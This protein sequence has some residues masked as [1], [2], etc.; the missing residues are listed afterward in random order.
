M[1][2]KHVWNKIEGYED[3]KIYPVYQSF[4]LECLK[5]TT[6]SV[7]DS[8]E[9]INLIVENFKPNEENLE[10]IELA[11]NIVNQSG[12]ISRYFFPTRDKYNPDK[13]RIHQLR[14][15]KLR[16]LFSID[17]NNILSNRKFRNYIEHFDEN[18]DQFLN[19]P[20]AGNIYPKVIFIN[21]NEINSLM[22]LF[23]AY[24]INEFKFISLN[25]E[26]EIFTLAEE[27]YRIHNLTINYLE[28]PKE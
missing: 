1:N 24:V 15:E 7:I 16:E 28:Y 12:I 8:W 22:Y 4:Y 3:W 10:L 6:T 2:S 18:L 17:Q 26:I 21:S 23:K 11:E 27:I 19:K 5:S 20:I 25:E 13:N 14:G 9:Q